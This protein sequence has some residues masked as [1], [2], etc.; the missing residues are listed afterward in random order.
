MEIKLSDELLR[1][2]KETG[3]DIGDGTIEIGNS[4]YSN[5]GSIDKAKEEAYW[6]EFRKV[7]AEYMKKGYSEFDAEESAK[8]D[9]EYRMNKYGYAMTYKDGKVVATIL[10]KEL[11]KNDKSEFKPVD[12]DV[13]KSAIKDYLNSNQA[14][15][16]A[17]EAAQYRADNYGFDFKDTENGK[18]AIVKKGSMAE[19]KDAYAR[20]EN[21]EA[22][23]KELIYNSLVQEVASIIPPFKLDKYSGETKREK[24]I[25]Y[26]IDKYN[27]K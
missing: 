23:I 11:D 6:E 14:V 16:D 22:R 12:D 25:N 2:L 1:R 15:L 3:I 9:V 27:I 13:L 8:V 7:K 24:V 26:I 18:V 17:N 10:D 19:V 5:E 4:P 20:E 21:N